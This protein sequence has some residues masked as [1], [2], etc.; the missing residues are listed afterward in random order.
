[1]EGGH[2]EN[3][4]GINFRVALTVPRVSGHKGEHTAALTVSGA[5]VDKMTRSEAETLLKQLWRELIRKT[6]AAGIT[7]RVA[8]GATDVNLFRGIGMTGTGQK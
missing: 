4:S 2:T 5:K 1:M 3:G 8:E 7:L 6:E